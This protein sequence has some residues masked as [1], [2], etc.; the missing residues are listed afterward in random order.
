M[1]ICSTIHICLL[2]NLKT[3]ALTMAVSFLGTDILLSKVFC[4][5]LFNRKDLDHDHYGLKKLKKRV[6]E[7][8]AVRKM[9]NSLKGGI[10]NI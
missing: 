10:P 4:I 5:S 8:L 6:I 9:K 2:T 1:L 3:V 7:Y